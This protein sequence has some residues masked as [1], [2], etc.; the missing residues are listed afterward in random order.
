MCPHQGHGGAGRPAQP[1][2]HLGH[3]GRIPDL[4]GQ[5]TALRTEPFDGQDV[6]LYIVARRQLV[7]CA[8]S[9]QEGPR[10][11]LPPAEVGTPIVPLSIAIVVIAPPAWSHGGFYL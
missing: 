6:G 4:F 11:T 10:T 3:V 9:S 1:Q 8:L 5:H 2:P 7:V